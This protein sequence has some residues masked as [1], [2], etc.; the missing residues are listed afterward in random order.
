MS[1][2][3]PIKSVFLAFD[4]PAPFAKHHRQRIRRFSKPQSEFNTH[5]I[6]S[7]SEFMNQLMKD[8]EKFIETSLG[9]RHFSDT[10]YYLSPSSRHGEAEF[11]I[12]QYINENQDLLKTQ[13]H[14]IISQDSDSIFYALLSPLSN[15][16]I[17]KTSPSGD[18]VIDIDSLRKKILTQI[19]PKQNPKQAL[20][21]FVLLD[22]INGSDLLPAIRSTDFLQ[23]W[24]HYR[25][26]T[27]CIFNQSDNSLNLKYLNEILSV[28]IEPGKD[29]PQSLSHGYHQVREITSSFKSAKADICRDYIFNGHLDKL[30]ENYKYTLG[31]E[32][33]EE[34]KLRIFNLSQLFTEDNYDISKFYQGVIW[35]LKY[36]LTK[37][38]DFSYRYH[39]IHGPPLKN[40]IE[41]NAVN[42]RINENCPDRMV[43][44]LNPELF[45]LSLS[46]TINCKEL[47]PEMFR[48]MVEKDVLFQPTVEGLKEWLN[49][50]VLETLTK[51]YHKY[52][53][54]PQPFTPT[55]KYIFRKDSIQKFTENFEKSPNK[56]YFQLNQPYNRNFSTSTFRSS[57][58][59]HT[60]IVNMFLLKGL[61]L[62]KK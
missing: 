5:H 31:I 23:M 28:N 33:Q 7:G 35:H 27:G 14:Y 9:K 44:P 10:A 6:T 48:P 45:C 56:F 57:P 43:N 37:C 42:S 16:K 29:W 4:G 58:M 19:D 47:V 55:T 54:T 59:H 18:L 50:N 12:F 30:L 40:L 1:K 25:T 34:A 51:N 53:T 24:N 41:Y 8:M 21:D 38:N 36:Y 46:N 39:F 13:N 49:P 60:S 22:I 26:G 3:R 2:M 11:K 32:K 15:I 17:L 20:I 61:K 62:I 52:Q